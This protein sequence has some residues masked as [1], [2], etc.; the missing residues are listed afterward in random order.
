[1]W[2]KRLLCLHTCRQS[3]PDDTNIRIKK[4]TWRHLHEMKDPGESF[5]DVIQE[6][7]DEHDEK[8]EEQEETDGGPVEPGSQPV[9]DGG[10]EGDRE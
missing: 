6:L 5:D 4:G 2:R 9:P 10:Q 7:L 8:A 1:M 3:V